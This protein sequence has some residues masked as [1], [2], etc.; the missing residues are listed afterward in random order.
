MKEGGARQL[1]TQALGSIPSTTVRKRGRK[2]R[3]KR[4]GGRERTGKG[5]TGMAR[6]GIELD[7]TDSSMP[8]WPHRS[9]ALHKKT[10]HC[11]LGHRAP[12]H[13]LQI[14][15]NGQVRNPLSGHPRR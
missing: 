10:S 2:R 13:K 12:W 6:L 1:S 3:Q 7:A 14:T 9:P 4:K 5:R 15:I 8:A 11:M